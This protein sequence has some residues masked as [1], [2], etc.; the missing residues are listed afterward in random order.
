MHFITLANLL[1]SQSFTGSIEPSA[2]HQRITRYTAALKNLYD[3]LKAII[4][5][6]ESE[7]SLLSEPLQHTVRT[8]FTLLQTH[9]SDELVGLVCT[10][11]TC[12][13]SFSLTLHLVSFVYFSF[14]A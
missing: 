10:C 12:I 1:D 14:S 7:I 9:L 5:K 3:Q 11:F 2:V 13:V 4:G 8:F 6:L